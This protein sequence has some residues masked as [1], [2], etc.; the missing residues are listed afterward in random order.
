MPISWTRGDAASPQIVGPL[1][2]SGTTFGWR[3]GDE[4]H[5]LNSKLG[6]R[7]DKVSWGRQNNRAKID[8]ADDDEARWMTDMLYLG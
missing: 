8:A 7:A 1:V 5:S 2:G 3:G 6:S 4:D